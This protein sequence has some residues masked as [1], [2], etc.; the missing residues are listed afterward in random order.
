MI[1]RIDLSINIEFNE[2]KVSIDEKIKNG[3][4]LSALRFN[5]IVLILRRS[6]IKIPIPRATPK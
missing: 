4:V 2:H 1:T 6:K 5:L 3:T